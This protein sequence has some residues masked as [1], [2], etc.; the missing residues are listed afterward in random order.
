MVTGENNFLICSVCQCPW[1]KHSSSNQF[2]TT[3]SL[4]AHL[5]NP[6]LF[7]QQPNSAPANQRSAAWEAVA[8][9]LS[10]ATGSSPLGSVNYQQTG[11]PASAQKRWKLFSFKS[12]MSGHSSRLVPWPQQ[13]A[14]L[15]QVE[16]SRRAGRAFTGR[17]CIWRDGRAVQN[18]SSVTLCSQGAPPEQGWEECCKATKLNIPLQHGAA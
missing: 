11:R 9:A 2:W 17:V 10:L 15:S 16:D 8:A 5:P 6:W 1:C 14:H 7:N 4:T 18:L 13:A 12:I 3:N